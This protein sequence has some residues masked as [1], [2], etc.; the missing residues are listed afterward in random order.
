MVKYT[1]S[2]LKPCGMISYDLMRL[3]LILYHNFSIMLL[4]CFFLTGTESGQIKGKRLHVSRSF[5]TKPPVVRELRLK[6]NYC[7]QCDSERK[8]VNESTK[9]R[10][11]KWVLTSLNV[12]VSVQTS[13]QLNNCIFAQT[14]ASKQS[15]LPQSTN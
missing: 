13:T 7:F 15:I 5:A 12:P 8:Q 1:F 6:H 3:W 9:A 14:S 4:G 2:L 10:L 11:E